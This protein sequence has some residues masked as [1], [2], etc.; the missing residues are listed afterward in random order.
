MIEVLVASV[1]LFAGLGAVLKAYS[2]AVSALDSA[3]DHLDSSLLL[4][5]KMVELDVQ[6]A[7]GTR[8]L[9]GGGGQCLMGAAAY[10]WDIHCRQQ[11]VTPDI[12]LQ[13]ALIQVSRPKGFVPHSLEC[14]W[15]LVR[16]PVAPPR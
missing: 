6:M 14:E 5:G 9:T 7:T 15:M 2:S 11:A 3:S 16:D 8:V 10:S 12:A 1:I 13:S 4:R